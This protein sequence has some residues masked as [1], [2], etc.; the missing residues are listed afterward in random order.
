VLARRFALVYHHI[1]STD[2]A[3]ICL[4][5]APSALFATRADPLSQFVFPSPF[6]V[7]R[8]NPRA[9]GHDLVPAAARSLVTEEIPKRI[10]RVL[11]GARIR[12]DYRKRKA[13][14][15]DGADDGPATKKR[16]GAGTTDAKG[17][18]ADAGKDSGSKKANAKGKNAAPSIRPGESLAHFNRCVPMPYL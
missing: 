13:A 3:L 1:L 11:D 9:R 14:G 7:K 15:L 12:E 4:I 10:S 17:S 18:K 5:N 16:K 6:S 2:W 8:T